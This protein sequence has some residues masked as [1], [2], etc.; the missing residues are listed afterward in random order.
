MCRLFFYYLELIYRTFYRH[1]FPA[2]GYIVIQTSHVQGAGNLISPPPEVNCETTEAWRRN[3]REKGEV[4]SFWFCGK[5][6]QNQ[7]KHIL[8]N[9]FIKF[10]NSL[11]VIQ[12][13]PLIKLRQLKVNEGCYSI[14]ALLL[15]VE[16]SRQGESQVELLQVF[17]L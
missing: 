1:M 13:V 16:W 10:K 11:F 15:L 4:L 12:L 14:C 3:G 8:N 5:K 9:I 6:R 17:P 7:E 2:R